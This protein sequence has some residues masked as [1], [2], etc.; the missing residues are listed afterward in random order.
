MEI[1]LQQLIETKKDLNNIL[2]KHTGQDY[3]SVE[4]HADRD[5]WMRATQAK[6]Y[7]IIDSVLEKK[8]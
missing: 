7:G 3:A 6:A 1:T 5:Y 2:S 4:R 8:T